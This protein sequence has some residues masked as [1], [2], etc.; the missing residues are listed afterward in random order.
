M[1]K[2]F[3]CSEQILMALS[4]IAVFQAL[5][6]LGGDFFLLENIGRI[7]DIQHHLNI[8]KLFL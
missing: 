1:S 8:R 4:F 2:V 7:G 6:A 3:V 5:Q